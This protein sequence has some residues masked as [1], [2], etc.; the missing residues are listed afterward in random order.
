MV[1][2]FGWPASTNTG[3]GLIA[4]HLALG[5]H[6][7]GAEIVLPKSEIHEVTPV[8]RPLLEQMQQP[9]N[10][11][12]HRV[13]I[14]AWGNHWPAFVE[15]PNRARVLFAVFEDT[16]IPDKA[17][18][19][20][21]RYDLV[22]TPSQWAHDILQARCV[23][24][25]V[26]HQGYDDTVF[27]PAPRRRPEGPIYVFSGGKLEFRKG[28]DIVVEAFK[29]FRET[30]EGKDAVLVTAWQNPWPKTMEGIWLS[31][32]VKGVPAQR[33]GMLDIASWLEANGVPRSAVIDLGYPNQA[34]MAQ[35]IRECDVAVFPNRCEGATNMVIPEVMAC[36]IPT[37]VGAWAGQRD[38]GGLPTFPITDYATVVHRC[39]LFGGTDGWGEGNPE[40]F[41]D[42]MQR[43]ATDGKGFAA[44]YP[45]A[46]NYAIQDFAWSRQS[47]VLH[48]LLTQCLSPSV[49]V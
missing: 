4:Y 16:A 5:L 35:A 41:V 7:H 32:Y 42:A 22:L 8:L 25:T 10:P 19:D 12:E 18:D 28:Q 6:R 21:H 2:E 1:I 38:L 45:V 33:N 24:S 27:F 9:R 34:Q 40:H 13:R 23:D 11:M 39:S 31:G 37:I 44:G 20:L 49:S 43:L 30:P 17:I 15:M 47:K 26:W 14:D 29:R 46:P 48:S 3:W 36:E